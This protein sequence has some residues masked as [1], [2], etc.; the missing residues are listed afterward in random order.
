VVRV[1]NREIVM[2]KVDLATVEKVVAAIKNDRDALA[3]RE[4]LMTRDRWLAEVD[5]GLLEMSAEA[6]VALEDA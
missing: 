4:A 1:A 2:V 5:A 6:R 3:Q